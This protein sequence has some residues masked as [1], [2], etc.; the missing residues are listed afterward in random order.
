MNLITAIK[1]AFRHSAFDDLLAHGA[2]RIDSLPPGA[3]ISSA[4]VVL[5][6]GDYS[7]EN[8]SLAYAYKDAVVISRCDGSC[9]TR[10]LI[11]AL[12]TNDDQTEGAFSRSA[13]PFM[14]GSMKIGFDVAVNQYLG[15]FNHLQ[16]K[17]LMQ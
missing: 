16:A 13:R 7:I 6:I 17:N 12:S 3:V 14:L 8:D 10:L 4:P 9:M 5:W 15:S 11:D 1:K 2:H